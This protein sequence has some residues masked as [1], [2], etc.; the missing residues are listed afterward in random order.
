MTALRTAILGC[1]RFARR[2]AACLASLSEVQLVGFCDTSLDQAEVFNQTYAGGQARVFVDYEQ[3]FAGLGLDLVY[4]CLPPYAHDREVELACRHGVHFLIEKPIAL[5][6]EL[7]DSMAAHVHASGVKSQV[8]FM[9][10]HGAATLRLK[11][12]V[13]H[14]SQCGFMVGR[15]ACNSLHR[16]W[17]RDRRKSGGQLTEQVIHMLDLA[18]FFLGEPVH[19]FSAQ[20]NLFHRGVEDYSSEDVSAT[21]IRFEAGGLAVIAATNGAIPNRWDY[22]WR[23]MLPGLTA[24][25][26]DAN[27]AVFHDTSQAEPTAETVAADR[28][29][30]LAETLDL[31]AAIRDDRPAAVPID[32]GV[33]TLRLALAAN[34]AAERNMPITLSETLPRAA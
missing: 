19:V 17:W 6:L 5:T 7:A 2:H 24:D 21:I 16:S 25:F 3:M 34:E 28:D 13:A 20:D 32:E 12:R 33:L 15:Y 18:R 14:S 22:D 23:L 9:Y 29:L 26:A 30:Y 31:L 27:H 11:E 8:G 1:G 4:I 10:R